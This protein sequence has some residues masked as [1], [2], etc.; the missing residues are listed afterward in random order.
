MSTAE[1]DEIGRRIERL[2]V[3][4]EAISAPVTGFLGRIFGS[5]LY[6]VGWRPRCDIAAVQVLLAH[7]GGKAVDE[8]GEPLP[9]RGVLVRRA[10]DELE[11]NVAAI[12][13]AT[14]IEKRAL[15]AHARW[16][17]RVYEVV[18]HAQ[19][20][21][22]REDAEAESAGVRLARVVDDALLAPPLALGDARAVALARTPAATATAEADG[23]DAT[24]RDATTGEDPVRADAT[25]V[26][27]LQLDTID[28]LLDA[29]RAESALFA[30]KRRLLEAARQLLLEI[31]AAL[32]LDHA[33]VNARLFSIARQVTRIDRMQALGLRGDV[34]LLHQARAALSRGQRDQL[35]AA[36]QAMDDAALAGSGADHAAV[37]A[38]TGRALALVTEGAP[39]ARPAGPEHAAGAGETPAQQ[40]MVRSA[41]EILGAE[42][43]ER[44][45]RGCQRARADAA[46]AEKKQSAVMGLDSWMLELLRNHV[47]PGAERSVLAAVLAVD[48][49]FDL[50]GAASPVRVRE[51]HVRRTA[52]P[53]PTQESILVPARGPEEVRDAVI[54]D[55]RAVLLD[56]AAGRLLARRYVHTDIEERERTV[57]RGEV[58]VYVLDGSTSMLG[59]RAYMRDA[60]LVAELCTLMRRMTEEAHTTRLSLFYRY[61]TRTLGPICRVDNPEAALEAIHEVLEQPR[62]GGTDIES[63]LIASMD[64]VR[65]AR[66]SDPELA[67][68]QIV[69]V[70]DGA[71]PVSMERV[72]EA[73]AGI[74]EAFPVGV[75][76]IALGEENRALRKLVARQRARG[77]RAFYHFLPDEFLAEIARGEM[78][79][80]QPIHM[81]A[82]PW[83][84][85]DA[86]Q[87]AE[88]L[89]ARVG[90][91]LHEL[92]ELERARDQQAWRALGQDRD[93]R[94]TDG[95]PDILAGEGARANLE[96]VHRDRR[97]LARRYARWFPEPAARHDARAATT[98]LAKRAAA[99]PPEP[100]TLEAQDL[101]SVLVLLSTI[102][103]VVELME[104][105]ELVRQADAV[106]LLERMLPDARLSPTRYHAVLETYAHQVAGALQAV[107]ASVRWGAFWRIEEP[108]IQHPA[109]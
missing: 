71:A 59:A 108:H 24:G 80:D 98:A 50:G 83:M 9:E 16:L 34:G 46:F 13:R 4:P 84:Q 32:D 60:I 75:S 44:I 36:L 27:E 63:A 29:A 91:L 77:E 78:D 88:A 12:E 68:A 52:V 72:A 53:F 23:R 17:R 28:H 102:A 61:F 30:R 103:E 104:H 100:D 101:E 95:E 35:F 86:R 99:R 37:A 26:L 54:T 15:A 87:A 106:D 33:G 19:R 62:T 65:E 31:S 5:F 94:G 43:V 70:T 85:G 3:A 105:S 109:R 14:V 18:V 48:G 45:E 97:A 79:G 93:A 20:L 47:A 39:P 42:V 6:R 41:R 25:R 7:L 49:C 57:M 67:R 107:H 2:T 55:P 58:R 90:P 89:N 51:Q 73:R 8:G 1:L 10:I 69:L 76:V 96:A 74:G 21:S 82:V 66:T 22:A 81:P 40:S 64:T 56:L 11:D 38:L 92:A